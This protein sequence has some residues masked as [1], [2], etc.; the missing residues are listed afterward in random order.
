[1]TKVKRLIW[2]IET[3][4]NIVLAWRTGYKLDIGHDSIVEERKII[5][6]AYKWLGEKKVTVLTWDKNK[7]DRE[8][9]KKFIEV[10]N[11]ADE[12][13]AHF[14]DSFDLPWVAGR[15]LIL[16]LPPIP[17]YKTV[18]TKAW[19][20]KYF[21]LNSNKLDYLAKVMGFE[22]K[23]KTD[24]SMWKDI[25]LKNCPVALDKM[26]RYNAE[27]VRQLEKVYLKLVGFCPTKTHAGVLA[28]HDKWTCPKDGSKNVKVSKTRVTSAGTVQYQMQCLDCG[29][30]YSISSTEHSKYIE[31]KKGEAKKATKKK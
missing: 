12:L 5:T 19:A 2:D 24:Y 30:Y 7:D 11:E 18:D 10:A 8:M 3:S 9:V 13:I 27:D 21:Y 22:G 16:G 31:W 25:T 14:G 23:T 28:G 4:P 17:R 20:S 29:S 1:M 6:I 26:A 15:C